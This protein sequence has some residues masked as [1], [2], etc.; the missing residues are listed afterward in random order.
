M[1]SYLV[2]DQINVKGQN[3]YPCIVDLI[4]NL[5]EVT[6]AGG[7]IVQFVSVL[8]LKDEPKLFIQM[9]FTT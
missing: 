2:W 7:V 1:L 8:T 3:P 9:T 5:S 4:D 6:L